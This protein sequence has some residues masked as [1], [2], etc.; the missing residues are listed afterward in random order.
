[1]AL[2]FG[3]QL[4]GQFFEADDEY[5][6]ALALDPNNGE[7]LDGYGLMV[8]DLGYV[9]RALPMRQR[10]L[11]LEPFVPLFTRL[12]AS[13]IWASGATDEPIALLKRVPEGFSAIRLANVYASLDRYN[14]AADLILSRSDTYLPGVADATAR[15]LRSAPAVTP[16]PES[17]PRLGSWLEFAYLAVGAPGR[18]LDTYEEGLK[19]NLQEPSHATTLW[20]RPYAGLRKTERFKRF[21]RNAGFVDYWRAK[22]WP[23]LCHPVGADDFACE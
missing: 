17:L 19:L 1:M 5:A 18:V 14:E 22:G 9:K 21:V 20:A 13:V 12:T 6:R 11:T 4:R 2:A 16:S 3:R 8:S 7:A 23:D 15:L 10:L